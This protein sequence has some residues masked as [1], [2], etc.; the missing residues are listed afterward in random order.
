MVATMTPD[1]TLAE[2]FNGGALMPWRDWRGD[3]GTHALQLAAEVAR[4][5]GLQAGR[6]ALADW[7]DGW[8]GGRR[9]S[10]GYSRDLSKRR[11]TDR[12]RRE[13][14]SPERLEAEKL[15]KR[16]WRARRGAGVNFHDRKISEKS[17]ESD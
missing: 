5:E 15:R 11:A 1:E 12:K 3:M 10:L 13:L 7:W 4:D 14:W 17:R 2:V 16:S 6:D 9:P 8:L